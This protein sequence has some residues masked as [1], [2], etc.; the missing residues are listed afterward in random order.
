MDIVRGSNEQPGGGDDDREGVGGDMMVVGTDERRMHV[1]AYNHWV[2]LLAGRPCPLIDALDPAGIADFGPN[3]VLL[4]FTDGHDDGVIRFLG[5]A[6]REESGT[7]SSI[8]RLS[9]VPPRSLLSRLTDHYMQIIANRAPIGFEAEFVGHRGFPMLYR[10]ILM[11]FSSDGDAIDYL[12]GVINWKEV[13]D[14]ATQSQ[15]A[16]EL[17]ES[18]RAAP[19]RAMPAAA[20]ADGPSAALAAPAVAPSLTER[21]VEVRRQVEAARRAGDDT[22]PSMQAALAGAYDFLLATEREPAGY[23]AM[24]VGAGLTV[25]PRAPVEALVRLVFGEGQDDHARL[26]ARAHRAGV[27]EG[28]LSDWI[29]RTAG[30]PAA[31]TPP[32]VVPVAPGDAGYVLLLARAVDAGSVEILGRVD[33]DDDLITAARDQLGL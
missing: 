19:R 24:L 32:I 9:Q 16:A 30:R 18:R 12:Y 6:L 31:A 7:D 3:S 8:V 11:P 28:E 14:T 22:A 27:G 17:A 13:V 26:L 29:E 20:W 5:H 21:L 25:D 23:A 33:A 15:L 2:S 1:R 10:G 4:D